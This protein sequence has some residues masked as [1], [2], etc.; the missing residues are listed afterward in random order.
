MRMGLE[1][2]FLLL[3][4]GLLVAI[5]VNALGLPRL[6]TEGPATTDKW[7][8]AEVLGLGSAA[9]VGVAAIIV[10]SWD[11]KEQLKAIR[12]QLSEMQEE[13]RPWIG[14]TSAALVPKDRGE[15]LRITLSYRNFGRQPATFERHA[16]AQSFFAFDMGKPIEGLPNW[17]D[18]KV[19]HP[20]SLCETTSAYTTAYPSDLPLTF[21]GGASKD[22]EVTDD[23][24]QNVSFQSLV[25]AVTKKQ[26]LYV[27][28]GC[29]TYV[30][31]GKHE[32]T[33]FCL[34]L[35]PYTIGQKE[36][37]TWKVGFCPYGNDNGELA[38]DE[39]KETP[40]EAL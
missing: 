14:P 30:A 34:I 7:K 40:T 10:S 37:S 29:F 38:Q 16:A 27:F 19:F 1:T 11:S 21:E 3:G 15:P 2:E 23:K 18:P 24:G 25:D 9:G 28:Y 4:W 5:V 8:V 39:A 20:R 31:T 12:G 22:G 36:L 13:S 32:F 6:R 17:K 26:V 33:T 35:D